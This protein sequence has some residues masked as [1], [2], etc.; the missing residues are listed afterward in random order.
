MQLL[1]YHLAAKQIYFPLETLLALLYLIMLRV[2]A[3]FIYVLTNLHFHANSFPV[4]RTF[5]CF[6][7]KCVFVNQHKKTRQPL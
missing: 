7:I 2:L 1:R 3:D 5:V 4:A 6:I